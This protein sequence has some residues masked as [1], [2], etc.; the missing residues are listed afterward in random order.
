MS[1]WRRTQTLN[2]T[3]PG[4]TI[5]TQCEGGGVLISQD[6]SEILLGNTEV[7]RLIAFVHNCTATRVTTRAKARWCVSKS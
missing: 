3:N 6:G 1:F 4:R 5:A 2:P 7:D